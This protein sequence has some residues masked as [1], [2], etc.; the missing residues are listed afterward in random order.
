MKKLLYFT[1]TWCGPCKRFK[2][3]MEN[4]S[5]QIP[6][7]FIDIDT[8]KSMVKKYG[9]TSVPTTIIVKNGVEVSRFT[10][11]VPPQS[12]LESYNNG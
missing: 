4:L 3:I 6:V 2:P 9:I 8:N 1:A 10:G 11:V 7:Q 12:L 5:A